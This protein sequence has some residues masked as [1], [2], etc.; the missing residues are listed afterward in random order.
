MMDSNLRGL[1][2]TCQ[3]SPTPLT[4]NSV[5]S[6]L[7]QLKNLMDSAVPT[8]S[9]RIVIRP[10]IQR[11]SDST[12]VN[13]CERKNA[14]ATFP[15]LHH[16][17]STLRDEHD[18]VMNVPCR[19]GGPGGWAS[20]KRRRWPRAIQAAKLMATV[21]YTIESVVGRM[22]QRAARPTHYEAKRAETKSLAEEDTGQ[23]KQC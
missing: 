11:S 15:A 19:N 1:P 3:S 22:L 16:G 13:P 17:H 9:M 14:E 8:G 12:I 23:H 10:A 20:R 18:E 5:I 21:S 2:L 4:C 7:L 6:S